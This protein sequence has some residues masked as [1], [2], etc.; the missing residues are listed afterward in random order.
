MSVRADAESF[1]QIPIFRDCDPVALQVMAFAAERQ[2]FLAGEVIVAQGKKATAAYFIMS[3]SARVLQQDN[4]VGRAEPGSLLGELSMIAGGIY[5]ISAV[6]ETQVA[7]A[8]LDTGL[9]LRLAEEY[10]GFGQAI[11][12]SVSGR[13]DSTVKELGS[14]RTMMIKST[15]LPQP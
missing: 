5:S 2:T 9:F 13:L 3:G 12:K 15:G 8:R 6:A 14:V 4:V 11:L 7:T 1:R 10:P